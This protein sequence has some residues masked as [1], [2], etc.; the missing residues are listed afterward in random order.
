MRAKS[1][2]HRS[3]RGIWPLIYP[4]L[5]AAIRANRSTIVFVNSRGLCERLACKLNELAGEELVRAHHGSVS[6]EKRADDRGGD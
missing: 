6:H 5:L 2:R 3:K 4:E 1:A